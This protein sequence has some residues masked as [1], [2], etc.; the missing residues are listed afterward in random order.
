MMFA[1][2]LLAAAAAVLPV[3]PPQAGGGGAAGGAASQGYVPVIDPGTGDPVLTL[4]NELTGDTTVVTG[5]EI[6]FDEG[7][8]QI[9]EVLPSSRSSWSSCSS[10]FWWGLRSPCIERK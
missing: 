1:A 6:V 10:P 3:L 4:T 8:V 5:G 2:V 9:I 7:D